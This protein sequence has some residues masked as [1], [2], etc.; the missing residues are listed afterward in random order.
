MRQIR[1]RTGMHLMTGVARAA[2]VSNSIFISDGQR[3]PGPDR[4]GSGPSRRAARGIR[5]RCTEARPR[6]S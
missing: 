1:G 6:R 3:R 5:A 4:F 2:G